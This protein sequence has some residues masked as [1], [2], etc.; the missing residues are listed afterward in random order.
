MCPVRAFITSP[1]KKA[2]VEQFLRP[3]RICVLEACTA[4][5]RALPP[6]GKVTLS[7]LSQSRHMDLHGPIPPKQTNNGTVVVWV[8]KTQQS[9]TIPQL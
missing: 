9:T 3:S 8:S 2:T 1:L 7:F 4:L 6:S 5:V